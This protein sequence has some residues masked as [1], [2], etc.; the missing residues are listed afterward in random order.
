MSRVRLIAVAV[1]AALLWIWMACWYALGRAAGVIAA[2][3]MT[4]IVALQAGYR[5]GRWT[6]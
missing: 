4:A 3:A 1:G 2:I 6:P 5:D